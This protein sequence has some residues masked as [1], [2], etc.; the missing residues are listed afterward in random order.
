M[1]ELINTPCLRIQISRNFVA[2]AV[3]MTIWKWEILFWRLSLKM[4]AWQTPRPLFRMWKKDEVWK[5]KYRPF[6]KD[7]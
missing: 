6:E 4:E 3:D 1:I 5:E 7:F 2:Y